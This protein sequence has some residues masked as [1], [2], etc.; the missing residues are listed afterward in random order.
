ML[1]FETPYFMWHEYSKLFLVKGRYINN[2]IETGSRAQAV[3]MSG[4]TILPE[5]TGQVLKR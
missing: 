5:S 1:L 4:R 2:C 3:L